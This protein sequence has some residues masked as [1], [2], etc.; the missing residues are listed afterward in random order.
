MSSHRKTFSFSFGSCIVDCCAVQRNNQE[1][2][3]EFFA[4]N[5][6]CQYQTVMV[7]CAVV[8]LVYIKKNQFI[9]FYILIRM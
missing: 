7:F 5:I 9:L 4:G 3:V 8:Q 6:F 2:L 1:K